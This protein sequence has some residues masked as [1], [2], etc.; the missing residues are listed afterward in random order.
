M[1]LALARLGDPEK[2]KFQTNAVLRRII[3]VVKGSGAKDLVTR[4]EA[5]IKEFDKA[6]KNVRLWRNKVI[7]HNDEL[8][9]IGQYKYAVG[10]ATA[11]SLPPIEH[12]E[13]EKLLDILA[14]FMNAVEAYYTKIT[15]ADGTTSRTVTAYQAFIHRDGVESLLFELKKAQRYDELVEEK[16]IKPES[17]LGPPHFRW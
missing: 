11:P 7:A 14:E 2:N 10:N 8:H 3:A 16:K 9:L 6:S 12:A 5:T 4:L 1:I 17:F 15:K 13:I